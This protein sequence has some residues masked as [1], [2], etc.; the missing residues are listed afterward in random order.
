MQHTSTF[1]W[2]CRKWQELSSF[3]TLSLIETQ[4]ADDGMAETVDDKAPEN[5]PCNRCE[6]QGTKIDAVCYCEECEE[7]FCA[8][9]E[10]AI[11]ANSVIMG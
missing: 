4:S 1:S 3:S 10:Q 6:Q 5:I 9:D 11:W 2:F 8:K 7:S